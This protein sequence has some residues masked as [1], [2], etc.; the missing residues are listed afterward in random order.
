MSANMGSNVRHLYFEDII[1]SLDHVVE[2]V[3][4]IQFSEA[5]RGHTGQGGGVKTVTTGVTF[6]AIGVRPLAAGVKTATEGSDS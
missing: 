2:S 6:T 5:L 3:F 1:V 4:P